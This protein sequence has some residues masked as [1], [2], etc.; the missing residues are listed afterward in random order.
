VLM[1]Y[2]G[3]DPVQLTGLRKGVDDWAFELTPR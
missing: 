1:K 2:D 3:T